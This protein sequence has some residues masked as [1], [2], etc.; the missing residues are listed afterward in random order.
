VP[1]L[2]Q[3]L[4]RVPPGCGRPVWI[5]DPGFDAARHVR[6][7]PCPDP[8]DEQA[9]LDVAAAKAPSP[10]IAAAAAPPGPARPA[11]AGSTPHRTRP[12][13]FTGA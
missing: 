5:D 2:R 4:V 12:P 11:P 6:I 3:R 10:A 8:G 9:L 13:S 1:R 7:L